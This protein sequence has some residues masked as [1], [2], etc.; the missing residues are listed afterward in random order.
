MAGDRF[1]FW[2]GYWNAMQRLSVERRGHMIT[3]LSEWAFDGKEPDFG[4]D[5]VLCFAWEILSEQVAE[6]V[7][8]G[9]RMSDRGKRGGE[10]SGKSRKKARKKKRTTA[11]STASSSGSTERKGKERNGSESLSPSG[12]GGASRPAPDGAAL[13]PPGF[14]V[15]P[16]PEGF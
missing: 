14:D 11:S 12:E 8:I 16:R 1:Y 7:D 15:P 4:G 3:A 5:E 10:A 2:R 9:R 13:A 6:S